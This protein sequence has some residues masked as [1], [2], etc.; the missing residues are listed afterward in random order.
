M[1]R[2]PRAMAALITPF[3]R[4]GE[5]DLR[6]HAR[7]VGLMRDRGIEG[8]LIGGSTG[9]G[10][11]LEP[12]ERERLVATAREAASRAFLLCGIHAESVRG[13][14]A[15][16]V[17]A[18]RGGADAA[19]V[20]TP[21]TLVRRRPDLIEGFFADVAAAAP[22]PVVLYSVPQ[23]T[24]VDLAEASVAA[25]APVEGIVGM[26]DSG[27]DPLRA[28]RLAAIAD[29]FDVLVGSTAAV[30]LA[31]GSGAYGAITASANYAPRLV[32]DTVIAARRSVRSAEVMQARLSKVAAAI[33]AHGIAAVKYAAGRAGLTAGHP[34]RPL[35]PVPPDV[36]TA[37]RRAL[38]DAGLV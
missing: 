26:K 38:R 5:L 22:L 20:V 23:V 14:V 33:E 24:G 10:P 21:T 29:D 8:V 31:I 7:N 28:G 12:G 35:R 36:R 32:R 27:G 15:G 18:E 11:Y 9:E 25:L 37:V 2:I 6:A 17:E 1:R 34:R 4:D 16:M 19:L 30:T 3:T 13:A